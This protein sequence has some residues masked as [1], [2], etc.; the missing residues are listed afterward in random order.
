MGEI[1]RTT[2]RIQSQLDDI[3]AGERLTFARNELVICTQK[4]IRHLVRELAKALSVDVQ[5]WE[6]EDDLVQNVLIRVDQAV[7]KLEIENVRA[8]FYTVGKNVRWELLNTR[9]RLFGPRGIGR[10]HHTGGLEDVGHGLVDRGLERE[11][12][13]GLW[14][15]ID[16]LPDE[17][18]EVIY[19]EHFAGLTR[20]L[21]AEL[22]DVS[23]KTVTRYSDL[24]LAALVNAADRKES[25]SAT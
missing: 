20:K 14:D 7:Q 16:A 2:E 19:L 10:N 18:Q 6:G 22:M 4:R 11:F 12:Y 5:R 17:W 8:F 25:T 24:A 21:T 9:D 1:E 3:L 13:V 23:T 15:E